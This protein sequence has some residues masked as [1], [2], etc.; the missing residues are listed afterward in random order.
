MKL[1]YGVPVWLMKKYLAD[2]GAEETAENLMTGD[3][4]QATV[5]KG[6]PARIGSLVVGR[7]NVEFSGEPAVLDELVERLHWKTMR[8]GG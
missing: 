7:I 4:W 1:T 2:M 5:Q 8:G 3:G 6:E